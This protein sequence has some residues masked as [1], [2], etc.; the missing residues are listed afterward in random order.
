MNLIQ[1]NR[2]F[3]SIVLIAFCITTI[4]GLFFDRDNTTTSHNGLTIT[5]NTKEEQQALIE[6]QEQEDEKGESGPLIAKMP[7]QQAEN[8]IL[9]LRDQTS[10][11]RDQR[12]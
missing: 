11:I 5:P 1:K 4:H 6:A 8:T 2:G 3:F 10:G 9:N 12:A 7:A